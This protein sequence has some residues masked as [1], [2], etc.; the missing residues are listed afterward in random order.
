MLGFII[1]VIVFIIV[2][3]TTRFI[4]RALFSPEYKYIVPLEDS[5]K[6]YLLINTK[7]NGLDKVFVLDSGADCN[8][9]D[10][11]SFSEEESLK[12]CAVVDETHIIGVSSSATCPKCNTL[13]TFGDYQTHLPIINAEVSL[14]DN[15]YNENFIVTD[16]SSIQGTIFSRTGIKPFGLL[17]TSFFK[18]AKLV[19]D[20]DNNVVWV[21]Y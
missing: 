10:D 1:G 15:V 21:K 17:G 7:I 18:K 5:D 4:Y 8:I 16:W 6:R 20:L 14:G 11:K 3:Y 9:I 19:I 2:S 12:D 13:L